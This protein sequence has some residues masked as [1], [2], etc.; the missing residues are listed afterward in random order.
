[1]RS[2]T[3]I[4]TAA[5]A[6]IPALAGLFLAY[7]AGRAAGAAQAA[8]GPSEEPPA[9]VT[10]TVTVA[11]IRE[12][13]L[14]LAVEAYGSVVPAPG[15]SVMLALPFECQVEKVHASEGQAVSRGALLLS[16]TGSPDAKLALAQARANAE[17][18]LKTLRQVEKRHGLKLA[19]DAALAQAEGA[20]E[21]AQ[22]QLLSLESR[23]LDGVHDLRAPADGVVV[24]L[25]FGRGAVAPAGVSLAE[26][27]DATRLEARFGVEPSDRGR[28]AVGAP[29]SVKIVDGGGAAPVAGRVRALSPAVNPSTRLVDA[30]VALPPGCGLPLG[31]YVKG[32]FPSASSPGLVVPYAAVLPEEKGFVLFTVKG[33]RAVRHAVAVTAENGEEALVAG[34]GLAAGDP[35]VVSGNYELEDGMAV[36]VEPRP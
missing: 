29:A 36:R 2:R 26:V 3:R 30:F 22:A 5:G 16:V 32:S 24:R 4:A 11:P 33:G 27:A 20:A 19:D 18:A 15:S 12:G 1:M 6:L 8:R 28:L 10:A 25:P 9:E 21:S 7:R 23:H 14:P 13:T 35:V 17:A 31:A 34:E